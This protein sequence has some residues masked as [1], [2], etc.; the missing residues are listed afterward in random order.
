MFV[1]SPWSWFGSCLAGLLAVAGCSSDGG[2]SGGLSLELVLEGGEQINQVDWRI[3]DPAAGDMLLKE[4]TIDTSA[5]GA[6][7]S[8]EAY[9]LPPG[10]PY[11]IEL[12]ATSED[13]GTTCKGSA[14]FDIAVGFVTR[15]H[16]MIQCKTDSDL[17]G[18]RVDAWVNICAQLDM[19]VVS[20]LD[21]SVGGLISVSAI[22]SDKDGD[23]INYLW[24]ATGGSFA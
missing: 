3:T 1:R 21:T 12:S 13:G 16:V 6:T 5:P 17:G 20:S 18:V 4:G 14:E 2:P 19:V 10:G 8:V 9:G 23:P 7:A 22:A 15:V 24:T 11:V